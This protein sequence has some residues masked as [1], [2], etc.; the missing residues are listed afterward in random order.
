MADIDN[1]IALKTQTPNPLNTMGNMLNLA[2]QAQQYQLGQQSLQTNQMVLNERKNVSQ[3]LSNPEK[4]AG[5][6]GEPDYNR[7]IS[8]VMKAA[9][10]TGAQYVGN[11]I[12]SHQAATQAKSALNTLSQQQREAVGQF[13][14]SLGNDDPETAKR[15]LDAY[16]STNP[17]MKPYADFT[18]NHLLAPTADN[19]Q[20]FKQNAFK[21][22]TMKAAQGTM[23]PST[24]LGAVT[25]NYVNTGGALQQINPMAAAAGA[26]S[27]VQ[28]TLPATTVEINP[29]TGQP[30][31]I[32]SRAGG[33]GIG[34]G[35][36]G[37]VSAGMPVG[38]ASNIENLQKEVTAVRQAGDQVPVQRNTNQQILR[39]SRD[40][41]TG[42][43]SQ[44]WGQAMAALGVP[45]GT[46][47]Q[48]LGKYLEKNAIQAMQTMGGAPSDARL[49]AAV[50]ANGS[51]QFNPGALQAVTKFNDATVSALDK[52]RQGIDK[53]VGVEG[54]QDFSK[55][56]KFKS[57]WAKNLDI[58]V[59]RVENAIRDGDSMELK[60]IQQELGPKRM[61]ELA[62]KRKNLESLA[63]TGKLP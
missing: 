19:P 9:P 34:T 18:W 17:Q 60:R 23:S 31:Y 13:V 43:G 20:A 59:F 40:T 21:A 2:N 63:T 30:N 25:P 28:N 22:A 3:V 53:T 57:E 7:L 52:Y 38:A 55:A 33:G 26:P 42:P 16:V 46:N 62:D 48:E 56:A 51:T 14:M 50:A 29:V 8:D 49:S 47:Y 37:P 54:T 58:D 11:V 10:T 32:G 27:Q 35:Q 36:V 45:A 39:L 12:A 6:D 1:E 44:Y 61:K 4:Y 24:Q 5:S 41:R 15:K